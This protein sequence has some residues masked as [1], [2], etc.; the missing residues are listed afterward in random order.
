MAA[1]YEALAKLLQP[2]AI[3]DINKVRSE[4]SQPSSSTTTEPY[5]DP[6]HTQ[7]A[8]AS[9]RGYPSNASGGIWE[10][11]EVQDQGTAGPLHH[12][13]ETPK[14]EFLYK[15]AVTCTDAFL[16]MMDKDASSACCEDLELRIDLPN[17][18][19]LSEL[20]LDV[21]PLKILLASPA[22]MLSLPLPH[23]IDEKQ[24]SAKWIAKKKQL[25]LT[26]RIVRDV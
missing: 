8:Q 21:Q 25:T 13:K 4:R 2:V 1:Q 3:E 22:Y 20:D 14:F 11:T 19:N 16:G 12:S 9:G 6:L 23:K 7:I 24:S 15:Q 17:A 18:N 26:M 5:V 10:H